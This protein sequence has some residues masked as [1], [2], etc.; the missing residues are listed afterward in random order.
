M[1]C[2]LL[3]GAGLLIRSFVRVLDVDLGFQPESAATLRVDP[4][5]DYKTLAQRQRI[6]QRSAA[7][8]EG[9]SGSRRRWGMTDALPLGAK[10]HMVRGGEGADL[11]AGQ[12][13]CEF[14]RIV[15]EGYIRAMGIPLRAGRDF[16]ER[17][18]AD[19]ERVAIVNESMARKLWPGQDAVG[20]ILLNPAVRFGG[21]GGG[22]CAASRAGKR[23]RDGVVF[24]HATDRDRP[25]RGSGGEGEDRSGDIGG[26]RCGRRCCR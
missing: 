16:E 9:G 6:L 5:P 3:V 22:G 20:Q 1:A 19:T 17:D 11:R 7:K 15:S 12:Y 18:T 8:G 14:I 13:P 21:R 23:R 24:V 2:V 10:S 4:G 26:R 25:V